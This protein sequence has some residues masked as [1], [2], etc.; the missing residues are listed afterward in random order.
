MQRVAARGVGARRGGGVIP[1]RR[2]LA[3][4]AATAAAWTVRLRSGDARAA[5]DVE[6]FRVLF[7]DPES[8]N[9]VGEACARADWVPEDAPGFFR[10][11]RRSLN[12]AS[13]GSL[14]DHLG[15]RVRDDFASGRVVSVEGWV[16]SETEARL[17]AALA[18]R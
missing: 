12:P 1:R 16:L 6:L 13:G 2:F 3:G 15:N 10:T 17:Y 9:R 4:F 11:L 18:A 5:D 8:L 7:R 14:K